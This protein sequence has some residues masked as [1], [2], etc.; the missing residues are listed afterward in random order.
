MLP[1]Q[2]VRPVPKVT[3]DFG[4]GRKLERTLTGNSAHYVLDANGRPLDVLPGLYG[5]QEFLVWLDRTEE[6]AAAY[7]DASEDQAKA[8]TLVQY[9]LDRQKAIRVDWQQDI[10]QV[11][12][13]LLEH[14]ISFLKDDNSGLIFI[15]AADSAH[16]AVSKAGPELPILVATRRSPQKTDRM[17]TDKLWQRLATLRRPQ[18]KLDAKTV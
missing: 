6:L 4:D 2:S 18:V 3:I 16:R 5:P 9:Y 17:V 14:G 7:H 10:K 11:A 15:D 12:P 13:Q 1:C 8:D